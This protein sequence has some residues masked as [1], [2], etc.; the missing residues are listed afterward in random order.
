[1]MADLKFP[2]LG[3]PRSAAANVLGVSTE[4]L[5]EWER[6]GRGPIVIR[7]SD[8]KAFYPLEG[9]KRFLD[10]RVSGGRK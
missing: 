7:V 10:S 2:D 3:L 6:G 1:M 9:L 4:T 8:R 5:R